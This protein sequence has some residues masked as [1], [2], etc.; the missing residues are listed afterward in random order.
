MAER[1]MG[2]IAFLLC[3]VLCLAPCLAQAASTV[4]AAEAIDVDKDCSLTL[5]YR[6][7]GT[8]IANVPVKLYRIAD[9]SSDFQYTLTAAFASSRLELNGIQTTGEWNVIRSTLIGHILANNIKPNHSAV[10]NKAGSAYIAPLK[11][12]LYL[13]AAVETSSC[14]FDAALIA[15]PG[16]GSNGLWQYQI[17]VSPKGQALP[18]VEPD[19]KLEYKILKLWKGDAGKGVRPS[20]VKVE[21]FR[22]GKSERTVTLSKENNWSYKW[23]APNDGASWKVVE[24]NVPEAYVATVDKRSTTFVLTN[25]LTPDNPPS[26]DLPPLEDSPQTGDS[27]HILLYTA[28]MYI[29]GIILVIVGITGKRKR[30]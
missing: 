2:I 27:P 25:T 11:P 20:R 10:T 9:V 17:T 13:A 5:S 14:T 3:L 6:Y 1:R 7:K 12:G 26:D 15:M 30:E 21:I 23:T 4:N 18:P 28:L 29:S 24:R 16:L 22:N 19:E 8:G